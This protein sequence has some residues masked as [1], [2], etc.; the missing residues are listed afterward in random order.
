MERRIDH[1]ETV[2]YNK[3]GPVPEN[4]GV[5]SWERVGPDAV[6]YTG[7]EFRIKT[8]GPDKGGRKFFGEKKQAVVTKAEM[9]AEK[10]RYE[11]DTGNCASCCGTGEVFK[12]WNHKTGTHYKMCK[13]CNGTGSSKR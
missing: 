13:K 6:I 3:I 12:R 11:T 2:F 10:V 4:F 8:K 1:G 5:F 7:A 9:E